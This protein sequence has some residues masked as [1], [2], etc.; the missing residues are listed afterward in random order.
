MFL[1]F[2]L[3]AAILEETERWLNKPYLVPQIRSCSLPIHRLL[4]WQLMARFESV[5]RGLIDS[6]IERCGYSAEQT[7]F[8]WKWIE[9]EI[10]LTAPSVGHDQEI[11]SEGCGNLSQ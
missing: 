9:S 11:E 4:R 10:D 2:V 6:E 5:E 8:V 3:F 7:R 1:V